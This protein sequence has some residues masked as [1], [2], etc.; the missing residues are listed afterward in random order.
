MYVQAGIH[1]C[2]LVIYCNTSG[3]FIRN[4]VV[5]WKKK[6]VYIYNRVLLLRFILIICHP[7]LEDQLRGWRGL[8]E[9]RREHPS[10][11]FLLIYFYRLCTSAV[12]ECY[13]LDGPVTKRYEKS[14]PAQVQKV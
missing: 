5:V 2:L 11:I 14:R 7:Y 8:T 1:D 9:H 3:V 4:S 6:D 10:M 12:N 13:T